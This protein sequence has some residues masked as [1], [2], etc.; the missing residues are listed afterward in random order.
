MG[1]GRRGGGADQFGER[2]LFY[3]YY[4]VCRGEGWVN[5]GTSLKI[6]KD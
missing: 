1:M 2:G 5:L 4:Y 6:E 3:S